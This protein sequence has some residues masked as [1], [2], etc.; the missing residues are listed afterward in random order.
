MCVVRGGTAAMA[1]EL[2][3]IRNALQIGSFQSCINEAEKLNV[4]G[5]DAEEKKCIMYRAMI[6]LGKFSTV[7]SEI[8]DGSSSD[9]QAIKRLA[10]YLHKKSDR[11][12]CV[13]ETKALQD[14]G[15][16]MGNSTVALISGMIYYYEGNFE[17]ALRCLKVKEAESLE[18][19]AMV[20]Q[21]YLAMNRTDMASK[22]LKYMQGIDEDATM[23]Q[24][25]SAWVNLAKGGEKIQEGYYVFEEL[26]QKYGGTPLLLNGQAVA[27]VLQGKI[28]DAE[29]ELQNA[30]E[31][32]SDDAITLIN[33]NVVAGLSGKPLATSQR[34]ISTL[35]DSN[36]DH[37]FVKNIAEK[38][39][40]FDSFAS[41]YKPSK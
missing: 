18:V 36:P 39:D 14:D 20:I 3:E 7:K 22:E 12:K 2:F 24:L 15:I 1:D 16:S 23:T 4:S 13:E 10:R 30:E 5:D 25:A 34:Y 21:I 35:Q 38:E 41:Q 9:L 6:A 8:S 26:T 33:L 11:A 40:E 37:P 28:D 17:D 19:L 31:K 29:S 27:C 32:K